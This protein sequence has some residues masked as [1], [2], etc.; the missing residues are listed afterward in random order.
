M[1]LFGRWQ[2]KPPVGTLIDWSHPLAAG[3]VLAAPLNEGAGGKTF[4]AAN[5]AGN[6]GVF[7]T[8]SASP[9]WTSGPYGNAITTVSASSQY[10]DFGDIPTLSGATRASMFCLGNRS[11]GNL[12]T[13]SRGTSTGE[14]FEIFAYTNNSVFFIAESGAELYGY[15][16]A[17]TGDFSMAM[18]YDGAQSSTA[19]GLGGYVNGAAQSLTSPDVWAGGAIASG[20][21][22]VLLGKEISDNL[23]SD[24]RYDLFMVWVGRVLTSSDVA[25]LHANPW[26]LFTPPQPYYWHGSGA[27]ARS[28]F[29]PATL[30]LGAGGSFFQSGVNS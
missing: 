2:T 27:A 6:I 5:Q 12:W 25:T 3:L 4:N 28:L 26:Q 22:D 23:F 29:L 16:N 24:G 21:Y 8:G 11:S 7:Q 17:P 30:S 13:T 15:C 10:A 20:T 9:T 19:A 1:A 14:R 18:T